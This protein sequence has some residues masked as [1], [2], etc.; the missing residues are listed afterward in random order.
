MGVTTVKLSLDREYPKDQKE[1][2]SSA[3]LFIPWNTYKR[4][5]VGYNHERV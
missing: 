4:L 3:R 5:I 2:F 1:Y